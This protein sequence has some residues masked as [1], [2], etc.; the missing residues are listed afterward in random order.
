MLERADRKVIEGLAKELTYHRK[1]TKAFE[2][3]GPDIHLAARAW[4]QIQTHLKKGS[5]QPEVAFLMKKMLHE[6]ETRNQPIQILHKAG[7]FMCP[8]FK[9]LKKHLQLT[10]EEYQEVL[11]YIL[12]EARDVHRMMN[13]EKEPAPQPA[14]QPAP[15]PAA[16][17]VPDVDRDSDSD[18]DGG[19]T[20]EEEVDDEVEKDEA[21]EEVEKYLAM[22]FPKNEFQDQLPVWKED[23][24]TFWCSNKHKFKLLSRVWRRLGTIKAASAAAERIFS[25]GGF[26]TMARRWNMTA[27]SLACIVMQHNWLKAG[28]I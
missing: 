27:E 5:P 17:P 24:S 15:Q 19:D 13:L 16:Q 18:D 6:F 7:A 26:I 23:P 10:E 12:K 8:N 14:A 20:E 25:V 3:N 9:N 4:K 22:K 21:L 28:L 11:D 2:S 1:K